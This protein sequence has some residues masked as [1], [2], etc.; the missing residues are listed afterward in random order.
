MANRYGVTTPTPPAGYSPGDILVADSSGMVRLPI[1]TNGQVLKVQS[2]TPSWQAESGGG[3][4]GSCPG[5]SCPFSGNGANGA[6][7]T[8][9]GC[10]LNCCDQK[11]IRNMEAEEQCKE[12]E[13]QHRVQV[14]EQWDHDHSRD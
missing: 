1:G 13:Y 8:N 4:G 11:F 2:G 9:G 7:G 12:K 3:G 6:N 5:G 10:S 14:V